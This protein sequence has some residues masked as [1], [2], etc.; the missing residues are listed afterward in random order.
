MFVFRCVRK[1]SGCT[2]QCARAAGHTSTPPHQHHITPPPLALPPRLAKPCQTNR[3]SL[4]KAVLC[5]A[6]CG[7]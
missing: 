6:L 5:V 3:G 4:E 2:S 1:W 7:S